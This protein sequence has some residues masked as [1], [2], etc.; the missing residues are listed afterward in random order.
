M[1]HRKAKMS[2][3]FDWFKKLVPPSFP[4]TLP[5]RRQETL[6]V[7]PSSPTKALS[8]FDVFRKKPQELTQ[9][10]AGAFEIFVPPSAPPRKIQERIEDRVEKQEQLWGS[11]FRE[12]EGTLPPTS[13]VFEVLR[14]EAVEESRRYI[15]PDE[16]PFGEPPIWSTTP[17]VMPTSFEL[18]EYIRKKWDLPGMYESVLMN[19]EKPDWK[20]AV[21]ESAHYGEPATMDVDLISQAYDPYSDIAK[22]LRIPDA[23][24]EKYAREGEEG[25]HRFNVE[26]LQ[27]MFDR[28]GKAL[29]AF[30]PAPVLRGWFELEPDDDMNFWVRYKEA[31]YPQLG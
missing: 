8:P 19:I 29:D 27:P 15:H 30:K 24:V 16:W 17:W 23:I 22:F 13:E 31:A 9:R 20:R 1:G 28:V 14:P 6:P 10:P 26:V 18:A 11:M 5:A 4:T 2:G 21:A 3:I 12:P 7:K 25:I